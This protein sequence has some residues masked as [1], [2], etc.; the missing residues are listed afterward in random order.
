MGG[1]RALGGCGKIEEFR[2]SWRRQAG[3]RVILY[4]RI[5]PG[6]KDGRKHVC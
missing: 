2:P 3:I 4:G 6:L 5:D 1:I